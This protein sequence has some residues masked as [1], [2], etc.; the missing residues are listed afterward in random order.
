VGGGLLYGVGALAV[1]LLQLQILRGLRRLAR[2]LDL[3]DVEVQAV[4]VQVRAL[5]DRTLRTPGAG[6]ASR[7]P[8][9]AGREA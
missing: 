2:R 5:A 6:G 8:A 9:A 3:L 7:L 1:V 4:S